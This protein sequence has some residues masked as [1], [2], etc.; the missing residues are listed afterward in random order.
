MT[1]LRQLDTQCDTLC[2]HSVGEFIQMYPGFLEELKKFSKSEN[3]WMR[4]AAAVS[5]IIPARSGR[6]LDDILEISDRLLTD[7]DDLVQKGYGWMLKAASQANQ[8]RPR[9]L[10]K[11]CHL[12]SKVDRNIFSQY[13]CSK[14]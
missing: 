1:V 14:K 11:R 8:H 6:F 5:L 10:I 2:N 3:R 4:R 7:K 9:R 12:I 13:L